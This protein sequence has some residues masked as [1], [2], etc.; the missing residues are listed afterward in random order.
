VRRR[1]AQIGYRVS[2]AA[3]RPALNELRHTGGCPACRRREPQPGGR[4]ER[5]NLRYICIA[6]GHCECRIRLLL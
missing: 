3:N 1:F 4:T 6:I 2:R 5:E